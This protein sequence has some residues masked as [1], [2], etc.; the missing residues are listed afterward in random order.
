[1]PE[2]SG[3]SMDSPEWAGDAGIFPSEDSGKKEWRSWQ[4][5]RVFLLDVNRAAATC[6]HAGLEPGFC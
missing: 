4:V 6:L 1:M 2:L 3:W 5:S